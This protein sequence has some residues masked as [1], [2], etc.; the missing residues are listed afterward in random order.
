MYRWCFERTAAGPAPERMV[1]TD[2]SGDWIAGSAISYRTIRSDGKR[3]LAGVMTGSWTLPAARGK[4]LFPAMI[5]QT[6][7]QV[8]TQGGVAVL[9]FA[10]DVSRASTRKLVD[11][12][13]RC[14]AS[15][16]AIGEPAQVPDVGH[17]LR[18]SGV[19]ERDCSELY[20]RWQKRS[21]AVASFAYDNAPSFAGQFIRRALPVEILRGDGDALI[22]V[23]RGPDTDRILFADEGAAP[24]VAVFKALWARAAAAGRKLYAFGVGADAE[25]LADGGFAVKNGFF[26][27]LPAS[28]EPKDAQICD[29]LSACRWEFQSGDRI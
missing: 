16:N 18:R 4:G 10:G 13:S 11:A 29:A 25:L 6:R 26:T 19:S 5:Q 17:K 2:D 21:G 24:R 22:L 12:G 20:V 15:A 9:G 3:L 1:A 23:E 28:D 14:V 7:E 27:I 8:R